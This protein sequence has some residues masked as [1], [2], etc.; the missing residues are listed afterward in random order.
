MLNPLLSQ[1]PEALKAKLD[2]YVQELQA[3]LPHYELQDPQAKV[4]FNAQEF[5]DAHGKVQ[6]NV[7]DNALGNKQINTQANTQI[8]TTTLIPY[9][10]KT[11]Y[12]L[13]LYQSPIQ[14]VAAKIGKLCA[15]GI[16]LI[17]LVVKELPVM[18]GV[19]WAII[20]RN[21][22]NESKCDIDTILDAFTLL[23]DT[24]VVYVYPED[25]KELMVAHFYDGDKLAELLAR[26]DNKYLFLEMVFDDA[27]SA[28][29]DYQRYLNWSKV[30]FPHDPD[31]K[32][33]H[34]QPNVV[35][36][37]RDHYCLGT[38]VLSVIPD[39]CREPLLKLHN[40]LERGD[41]LCHLVERVVYT[42]PAVDLRD[43]S[44]PINRL[45]LKYL[46]RTITQLHKVL[47]LYGLTPD[48]DFAQANELFTASRIGISTLLKTAKQYLN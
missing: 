17:T 16:E 37:G 41:L 26:T 3:L 12:F 46:P 47:E 35:K 32:D 22:R 10:S 31:G 36:H 43:D 7:L 28:K 14:E 24:H 27:L 45:I 21:I 40:E 23:V 42:Q 19:H 29:H 30:N 44:D 34:L 25:W 4:S 33:N 38:Y 18:R 15:Q 48:M 9:H 8:I 2:T 39:E 20:L 11:E 6:G 1:L 13:E 5:I